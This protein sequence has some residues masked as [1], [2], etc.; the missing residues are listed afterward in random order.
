M[1]ETKHDKRFFESTRGR[2]VTLLHGSHKTV[3][4]LADAL[5]LSDNAV[6]AHLLTLERDGLVAQAGLVKGF[7]KPHFVYELGDEARKLFPRAYDILF[8]R[9]LDVIKD[10][11]SLDGVKAALAAVGR[12]LGKQNAVD[13]TLDEKLSGTVELL[14]ELGGAASVVRENGRI[15]IKSGSCPFAE[16]VAEHP[17]VCQVAESMIGEMVGTKVVE[18]C[19]RTAEP[20]CC[21]EIG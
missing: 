21:F 2:I 10:G 4:E 3:N 16:A 14:K 11:M 1:S 19:D 12:K 18:R 17:E 15:E 9:L 13:G 5:G 7:R 8:N 20:K 6:R